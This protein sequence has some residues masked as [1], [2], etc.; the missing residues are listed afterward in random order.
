M[1]SSAAA[2][3]SAAREAILAN[4]S[5]IL[6]LSHRIHA[7]PELGHEER[8]AS[9]W[10]AEELD[11]AGLHVRHGVYD[12]ETAVAARR[13]SGQLRVGVFAEYDALPGVGHA[14]GHN[15]IAAAAVGAAWGLSGVADDLDMSLEVFGTPAEEVADRG[16]K[17]LMLERGAFDG[18]HAAMMVHPTPYEAVAPPLIAAS[19]FEV[20][21]KGRPAHAA[22]APEVGLNA[23]D[24]MVISQL[25]IGLMRQ[26]LSSELRVHGI[27]T[28]AGDAPNIIPARSTARYMVRAPKLDQALEL[29]SRTLRCFEAGAL[30]SGCRLHVHGGDRPYADVVHDSSMADAYRRN[31]E[32]LG[33]EFPDHS[34]EL[35]RFTPSTDMGNVSAVVPT[36]HPYI[37]VGSWPAVNHQ[38]EFA[39][40]C[41]T[42]E[43]DEALVQGAV[44]MAWTVI[45][46]ATDP[47]L[48]S[49][50][51]ARVN[52]GA[53]P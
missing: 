12:L 27:V 30:A 20:E 6:D 50:L 8:N 9:A 24:A 26:Q 42:D 43:A 16:G 28:H 35:S 45:D 13:G 41:A 49:H 11:R 52:R 29:R 17:I 36:I 4:R 5:R 1:T 19:A 2:L 34:A 23:A 46:L 22:A 47:A 25:A 33:R 21:F 10:V 40:F 31:A 37:R 18:L 15:M 3:K 44:A 39:A 14:C 7:N 51:L 32:E 38:P 53:G 48:R